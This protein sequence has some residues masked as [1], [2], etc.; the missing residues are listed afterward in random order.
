MPTPTEPAVDPRLVKA[1]AHPLRLRVLT[2]LND[3]IASPSELAERLG[4]RL[5][6]VSYHVRILAELDCI[7]LVRTRPVRGAVEHYYRAT[8][9]PALSEQDWESLPA[10]VR[11]SMAADVLTEAWAD[12]TA[13]SRA[14]GLDAPDA[15]ITRTALVLDEQGRSEIRELLSATLERALDIH[16]GSASRLG[17]APAPDAARPT[18]LVM[19]HFERGAD[20]AAPEAEPARGGR[21]RKRKG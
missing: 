4:E 11:S 20:G 13:A 5:G 1:M 19:L 16:A 21:G 10:S 17:N 2:L 6:N 15:H 12:V 14:G 9:R 18:R 3:G 8:A 7:E